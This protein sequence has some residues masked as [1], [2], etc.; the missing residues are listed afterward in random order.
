MDGSNE[1][2]ETCYYTGCPHGDDDD[3]DDDDD[4]SCS[5]WIVM[6]VVF[7]LRE[8]ESVRYKVLYVF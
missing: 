1:R 3:D 8:R 4:V 6:V 5:L 7:D 2:N